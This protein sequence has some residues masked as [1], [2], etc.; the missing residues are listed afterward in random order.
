MTVL[1]KISD[2]LASEI[3]CSIFEKYVQPALEVAHRVMSEQDALVPQ[4]GDERARFEA[5]A[6]P[7]GFDLIRHADETYATQECADAWLGWQAA[8]ASNKATETRCQYCDGTGDVHSIDGEWR[9]E[10]IEC[11]A[12]NKAA[13]VAA[14]V[15]NYR[16]TSAIN[17]VADFLEEAAN[18]DIISQ[19]T[20]IAEWIDACASVAPIDFDAWAATQKWADK[21]DMDVARIGWKAAIE[22]TNLVFVGIAPL[23]VSQA[24]SS[25]Y[26]EGWND[27]LNAIVVNSPA[28]TASSDE[29]AA[30]AV[31][32]PTPISIT[33]DQI[34]EIAG[35]YNLG[36]PRLDALRGFVNE[37]IIVN[38]TKYAKSE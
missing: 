20:S 13:A 4:D 8:L 23:T 24:P 30:V 18:L 6:E 1:K 17:A 3:E 27:C 28:P 34:A 5:W 2:I 7:E 31:G 10:C 29:A 26:A 32:E 16:P 9:G 37:V 19:F 22:S 21:Y 14:G 15:S 12:S 25:Q 38:G 36:N 33:T 35:K 11:D